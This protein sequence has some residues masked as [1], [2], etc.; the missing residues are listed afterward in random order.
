MSK[1]HLVPH[2]DE[3]EAL[4]WLDKTRRLLSPDPVE[5]DAALAP[6]PTPPALTAIPATA[7]TTSAIRETFIK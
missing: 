5:R 4:Y 6:P 7:R 1:L 2:D 3:A